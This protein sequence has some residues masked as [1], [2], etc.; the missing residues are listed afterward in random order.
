MMIA[1]DI[2]R[3]EKHHRS[4]IS[5][6]AR[7]S[8]GAAGQDDKLS[9]SGAGRLSVGHAAGAAAGAGG[10]DNDEAIPAFDDNMMLMENFMTSN[11]QDQG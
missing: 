1:V 8:M 3:G 6:I 11:D 7:S 9:K 2:A 10:M 5:E 4:T